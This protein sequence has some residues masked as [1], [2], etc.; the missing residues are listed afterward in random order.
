MRSLAFGLLF[1]LTGCQPGDQTLAQSTD[2]AKSSMIDEFE[3]FP[4]ELFTGQPVNPAEIDSP[5]DSLRGQL[6]QGINFGGH[7]THV[8]VGCG[9]GCSADWF[10]DR[11]TGDRFAGPESTADL[12]PL[13]MSGRA[14]SNLLKV[15]WEAADLDN[16]QNCYL[17]YF[18][19]KD[20]RFTPLFP[21]I[22]TG[23]DAAQF[24][25]VSSDDS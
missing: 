23:C 19:W 25:K 2:A 24:P 6:A 3:G 1:A 15:V 21:A 10:Y 12:T 13:L 14:D 22:Q 11:R 8:V 7:F 17:Q 16:A 18:V 20:G 5:G 4:A 9:T